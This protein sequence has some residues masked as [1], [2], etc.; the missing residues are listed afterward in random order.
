[1]V[2]ENIYTFDQNGGRLKAEVETIQGKTISG[3]EIDVPI[4]D[5]ASVKVKRV[6]AGRSAGLAVGVILIV[7]AAI[8]FLS[9]KS[10]MALV[11]WNCAENALYRG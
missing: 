8:A 7:V 1:M 10:G 9:T 11:K 6:A 3:D 4:E 2:D 5:I